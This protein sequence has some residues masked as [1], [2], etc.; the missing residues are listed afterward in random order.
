MLDA[1]LETIVDSD[2]RPIIHSDRGGHYR[3]SGWLER[4]NA[5]GLVRSM[6]R[7][8]SSQDNAACE[9]FFG[10]LKNEFFYPRDW[11][12]FT[13]DQFIDAVDAYIRWYNESRI[14]MSLGGR[15]PIEYR[16]SLGIMT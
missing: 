9:G 10:R 8:A 6:S 7:K 4:V 13:L 2:A 15:S 5:A 1:A 11:R 16:Q 14:K 3:W 12:A